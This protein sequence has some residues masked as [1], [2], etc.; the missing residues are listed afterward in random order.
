M[1][2]QTSG[3][4]RQQLMDRSREALEAQRERGLRQ[5][6]LLSI[7]MSSKLTNTQDTA[8]A[9]VASEAVWRFALTEGWVSGPLWLAKGRELI[10]S[11]WALENGLSVDQ[12]RE[13][14]DEQREGPSPSKLDE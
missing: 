2:E 14:L 11:Y 10:L 9:K 1:T 5:W 8:K 6:D 12:L 3:E 13:M 4:S 7:W